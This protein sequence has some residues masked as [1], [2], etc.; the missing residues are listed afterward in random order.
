M[1]IHC[2][3]IYCF[4]FNFLFFTP[5]TTTVV[6]VFLRN[7]LEPLCH[8]VQF[9][10]QYSYCLGSASSIGIM[11]NWVAQK[12]RIWGIHPL[13][14]CVRCA[15]TLTRINYWLP[16]Y[17]PWHTKLMQP[18]QYFESNHQIFTIRVDGESKKKNLKLEAILKSKTVIQITK[19]LF[20]CVDT[21]TECEWE[22]HF[23]V[24]H[25]NFWAFFIRYLSHSLLSR[26][27]LPVITMAYMI[28]R[29]WK[30]MIP[31]LTTFFLFRFQRSIWEP[32]LHI[33]WLV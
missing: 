19:P 15:P 11:I 23:H 30:N 22:E 26:H 24:Q 14:C 18:W 21:S 3:I 16:S 12:F 13:L 33:Y 31:K 4:N 9:R 10:F 5:T 27:H 2:Q 20:V 8:C 7:F 28:P 6:V 32:S 1:Q 17:S 29:P 25:L